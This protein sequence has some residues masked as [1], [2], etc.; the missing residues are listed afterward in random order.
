M[1]VTPT[2]ED[3]V[4]AIGY[5]RVSTE[6]QAAEGSSLSAQEAQLRAYASLYGLEL[7]AVYVDAGVSASTLDRP[8]LQEALSALEA[9][10]G[11]AL[12]VPKL[13]RL[14]RSVR[15][16]D[17]LLTRYFARPRDPFALVSVAEQ[18]DTR[19]ATG[20]LL[21]HLLTSVTQWEREVIGERTSAVMRHMQ[22]EGRYIGG[23][24]PFGFRVEGGE[25]LEEEEEQAI[26]RE[27]RAL[28]DRG[29]PLRR[30]A[31]ELNARGAFRRGAP[32]HAMAVSRVLRAA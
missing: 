19:S 12:I 27:L 2:K 21:L 13:D 11:G 31:E 32:W 24:V 30:I 23:G 25:L 17:A 5:V 15:D 1:R 16:L 22:E 26:L 29:L 14:T 10:P 9:L 28:R 3:R 6:E 20:R 4:K 18:V 8:A 7:V